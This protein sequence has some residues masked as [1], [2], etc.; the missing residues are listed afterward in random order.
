[1]LLAVKLARHK[2]E[3]NQVA[4]RSS[5][6]RFLCLLNE[7]ALPKAN[8]EPLVPCST[9]AANPP[10][11]VEIDGIGQT[12]HSIIPSSAQLLLDD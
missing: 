2:R 7:L 5:K 3:F 8:A 12:L 4:A 1:M 11:P 10:H 6:K 9:I